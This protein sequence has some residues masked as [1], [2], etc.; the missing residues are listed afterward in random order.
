MEEE[1]LYFNSSSI[2]RTIRPTVGLRFVE[3]EHRISEDSSITRFILQQ[4]WM[5]VN[6]GRVEWIDI[7]TVK[8]E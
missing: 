6:N 1:T 8:E 4:E 3:R 2:G 5:D 7:P